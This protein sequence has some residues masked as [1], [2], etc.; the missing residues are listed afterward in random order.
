MQ[1]DKNH[2]VNYSCRAGE[3]AQWLRALAAL[4]GDRDLTP[5]CHRELISVCN[6]WGG[7][8]QQ[9]RWPPLGTVCTWY[10]DTHVGKT[11]IHIK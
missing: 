6:S 7:G 11:L 1:F 2:N 10:T 4:A 5:S 8:I 3:V 9:L